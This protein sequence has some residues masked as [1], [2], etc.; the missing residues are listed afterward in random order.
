VRRVDYVPDSRHAAVPSDAGATLFTGVTSANREDAMTP[1]EHAAMRERW[2]QAGDEVA[3]HDDDQ[4]E[5][6]REAVG[7]AENAVLEVVSKAEE[8]QSPTRVLELLARRRNGVTQSAGALAIQ[9]LI[10]RGQLRLTAEASLELAEA[11]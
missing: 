8:P 9:R 7:L 1:E 4:Q 3:R 10:A 5:R 2:Q 11:L 6:L